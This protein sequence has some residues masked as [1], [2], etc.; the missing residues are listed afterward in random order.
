MSKFTGFGPEA[1]G[2]F[3]ALAFHQNRDWFQENKAT[4]ETQIREPT[5][6]LVE[7][8]TERFAAAKIPLMGSKKTLFRINRDIRFA[9]DKRPYQ[10]HA[11]ATLTRTGDKMSDGVLYFHIAPPGM[12]EWDGSPEGSFAAIGFHIPEPGPLNAIRT[13]IKK[14]PAACPTMEAELKKAKL[15]LGLGSQLTRVPRGCEDMKG[16]PVEGAIRLKSY[17][18]EVPIDDALVTKPKLADFLFKVATQAKPL[19]DFGWKAIGA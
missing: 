8:L 16:S 6:A 18:V 13:A 3:K 12:T 11:G 4:Y 1:L 14:K 2:F 9:K 7:D 10:T 19:L 15:K 17:M 5:L